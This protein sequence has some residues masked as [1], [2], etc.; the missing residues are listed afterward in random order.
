LPQAK[1]GGT[2]HSTSAA[3]V[4]AGAA[5]KAAEEV[6]APQSSEDPKREFLIFD[7]TFYKQKPDLTRYGLRPV[8]MVIKAMMWATGSDG[9]NLPDRDLVRKVAVQ[10]S[11]STRIAVLDIEHWPL[12]GD[13]ALVEESI[14]KYETLIQWFKEAA[15][16]VKVGYYGVVPLRNYWDAIQPIDSPKYIAW[17]K[18]NDRMASIARLVDI[19]FPSV[20]T[21]YEDQNGWSKYAVQQIRE[22]RRIGG[23]KPVY[24]FLWEEYHPSDRSLAGT[25]LPPDYW[26]MELETAW[27]YADGVVIWGGWSETW[28]EAAPW[29]L[30]T[31]SFLQRIGSSGR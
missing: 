21:F 11:K 27:K 16:A 25:H 12:A 18:S 9:A 28:D 8:S 22:A 7:A 26:R 2:Y 19:L 15:P 31:K 23:D 5:L 20:Y 30:E 14:R 6:F 4:S 10:V 17:Q 29:W 3:N 24:V 1:S 13:P